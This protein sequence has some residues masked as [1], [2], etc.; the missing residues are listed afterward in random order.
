MLFVALAYYF[1]TRAE[2]PILSILVLLSI[3]I[4]AVGAGVISG[5]FSVNETKDMAT[6][7]SKIHGVGA[8]IGFMLLLFFPLLSGVM[9]FKQNDIVGGI[10]DISSF[11][12]SLI[13]FVCF[14]MG[15][16]EQFQNSVLKYEGLWER[17]TLFSMYVPFV[18]KA[19][20]GLLS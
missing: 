1:S 16:K 6:T 2:F 3:G 12:L 14:V 19:I 8:A 18:H 10:V 17:L 4:F 13:F 5:M 9:L 7:A 15:D 11:I 20:N